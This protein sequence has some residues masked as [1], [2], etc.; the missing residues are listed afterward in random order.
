MKKNFSFRLL[1]SVAAV[2]VAL[3]I[4]S[5]SDDDNTP[6]AETKAEFSSTTAVPAGYSYGITNDKN[7]NTYFVADA[8]GDGTGEITKIGF[9]LPKTVRSDASVA[10]GTAIF[11]NQ[12]VRSIT[13]DGV[14]Y[15]FVANANGKI[16]V[17]IVCNGEAQIITDV[18]VSSLI[19]NAAA[20]ESTF[21]EKL[22]TAFAQISNATDIIALANEKIGEGSKLKQ[23]VQAIAQSVTGLKSDAK[24]LNNS[25][26]MEAVVKKVTDKPVAVDTTGIA[27]ADS[28]AQNNTEIEDWPEIPTDSVY[29]PEIPQDSIPSIPDVPQDSIGTE[30]PVEPGDSLPSFPDVPTDSIGGKDSLSIAGYMRRSVLR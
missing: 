17:T 11:G 7:G 28:T 23:E 13:I 12:Q 10:N 26:T 30:M 27:A 2:V 9:V 18:A 29:W 4:F 15:K 22:K 20:G 8:N 16:D 6:P 19:G 24:T 1:S 21:S 25:E 3:A 14:T 5:C